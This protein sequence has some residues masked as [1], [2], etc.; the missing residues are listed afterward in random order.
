EASP[1]RAGTLIE[2]CSVQITPPIGFV[3]RILIEDESAGRTGVA[4][5]IAGGRHPHAHLTVAAVRPQVIRYQ[6]HR[7]RRRRRVMEASRFSIDH[8]D[9]A[10]K[11][12]VGRRRQ[13]DRRLEQRIEYASTFGAGPF[14]AVDDRSS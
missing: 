14:E 10:K 7:L 5:R 4:E 11:S 9:A 12:V 1:L 13:Y 3:I 2:G 8:G 6:P